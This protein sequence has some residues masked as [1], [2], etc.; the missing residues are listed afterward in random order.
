[1][2]MDCGGARHRRRSRDVRSVRAGAEMAR[3]DARADGGRAEPHGAVDRDGGG[4]AGM[5][6]CGRDRIPVPAH[7]TAAASE[8]NLLPGRIHDRDELQAAALQSPDGSARNCADTPPAAARAARSRISA[9]SP[10]FS[11]RALPSYSLPPCL[12]GGLGWGSTRFS[13]SLRTAFFSAS[14]RR[15]SIAKKPNEEAPKKTFG[16]SSLN[17]HL[18]PPPRQLGEEVGNDRPF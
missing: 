11:R 15:A 18:N 1:M 17:P 12:G 6:S 14:N 9:Q 3:A 16:A 8:R 13:I 2:A 10:I 4:D 7:D 5:G